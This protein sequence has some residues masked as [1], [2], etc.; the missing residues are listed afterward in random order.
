MVAA[1]NQTRAVGRV[2]GT[3][4]RHQHAGRHRRRQ[5]ATIQ[6][7][8]QGTTRR[9]FGDDHRDGR[10]VSGHRFQHI[11][12]PR[13]ARCVQASRPQR[14]RDGG[15]DQRD[16]RGALWCSDEHRQRDVTLQH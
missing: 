16:L 15:T 11:E 5:R 13:C 14:T 4:Q 8:D 9:P 12:H 1:E 10:A 6:Q 3:S 7:V 2:D